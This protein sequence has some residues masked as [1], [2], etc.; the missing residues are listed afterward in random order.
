MSDWS[1]NIPYD[2]DG[3][4]LFTSP[5]WL[6]LMSVSILPPTEPNPPYSM[7]GSVGKM[8]KHLLCIVY[9]QSPSNQSL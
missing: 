7:G 4:Y 9:L 6:I 2:S 1:E 3:M 5:S 8:G